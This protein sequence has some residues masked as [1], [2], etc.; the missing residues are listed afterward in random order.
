MRFRKERKQAG[1][2]LV[3]M[4]VAL[5]LGGAPVLAAGGQVRA[6]V[7]EQAW[8]WVRSLWEA[9]DNG[10]HIDPNGLAVPGPDARPSDAS[11]EGWHIDPDGLAV[12]GPD[13]RPSDASDNGWHID[14]NG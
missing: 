11:D 1:M 4:T 9:V 3:A 10:P 5:L 6:S 12:P 13:A 2:I 7:L 8:V 14:P